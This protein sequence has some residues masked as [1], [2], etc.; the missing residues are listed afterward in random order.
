M[1]VHAFKSLKV[2]DVME[3]PITA[4]DED[5][6]TLIDQKLSRASSEMVGVVSADSI[7]KGVVTPTILKNGLIVGKKDAFDMMQTNPI[8]IKDDATIGEAVDLMSSRKFDKLPVVDGA[9]HFV[10]VVSKK[11]LL[12]RAASDLSIA[13]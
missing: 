11:G 12:R 6:A 2:K 1:N 7:L 5:K 4:Q 9:G 13:Y 10:G 8:A 3:A